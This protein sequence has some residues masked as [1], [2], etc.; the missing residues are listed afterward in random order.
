[1]SSAERI[2]PKGASGQEQD[3]AVTVIFAITKP[4]VSD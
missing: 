2:A 4:S 1:M 3:I